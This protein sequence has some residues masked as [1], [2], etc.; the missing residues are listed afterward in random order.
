M[1]SISLNYHILQTWNPIEISIILIA[2]C[3]ILGNLIICY[4][5]IIVLHLFIFKKSSRKLKM[6]PVRLKDG[7]HFVSRTFWENKIVLISPLT[8]C[9]MTKTVFLKYCTGTQ[10]AYAVANPGGGPGAWAPPPPLEMLKV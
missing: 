2:F 7:S 3:V 6:A 1:F 10:I 4:I 8:K 5:I 9:C